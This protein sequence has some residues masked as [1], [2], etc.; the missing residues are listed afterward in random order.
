MQRHSRILKLRIHSA[1][2]GGQEVEASERIR[3]EARSRD[4]EENDR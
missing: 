3:L 2:V 1:A 4:E